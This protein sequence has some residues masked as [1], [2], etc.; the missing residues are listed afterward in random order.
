MNKKL[1]TPA[2]Q[3]IDSLVKHKSDGVESV[4]IDALIEMLDTILKFEK[5]SIVLSFHDGR[6]NAKQSEPDLDGEEYYNKNYN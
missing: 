5:L 1:R 4:G 3:F 6:L 2:K